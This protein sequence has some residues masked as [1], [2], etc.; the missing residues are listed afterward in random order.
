M[1]TY[2]WEVLPPELK[3]RAVVDQLA[4]EYAWTLDALRSSWVKF[5]RM[6][7]RTDGDPS[8]WW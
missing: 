2:T 1:E 5:N 8:F 4:A 7:D 3:S 6:N